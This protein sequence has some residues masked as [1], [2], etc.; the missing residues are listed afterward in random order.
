MQHMRIDVI[1][2]HFVF[3][4]GFA[5]ILLGRALNKPVVV[6]ARGSDITLGLKLPLVNRLIGWTLQHAA[7]VIAVSA[8]LKELM[9]AHG[10][11]PDKV[12][13]IP[14][15]VDTQLFY[16][17]DQDAARHALGLP[18][19]AKIVL[20]VCSLVEL[21]GVD[22]L[23]EAAAL[24]RARYPGACRILVVGKGPE[25]ER[26]Q[27][28]IEQAGLG[29]MVRLVG[30]VPNRELVNWYNAA[31]LFFLGSSREG[32][33]NVV[34][35]ALA[36]GTPVVAT[37]VSGIPEIVDHD[38]LGLLVERTPAAFAAGILAAFDTCWDRQFILERGRRRSWEQVAREVHAVFAKVVDG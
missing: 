17:L 14:N 24:V 37:N 22:L 11:D 27:R 6:S 29:D 28:Q 38:G 7:R 18:A 16:P 35:E 26:L 2:A 33:P 19:D 31:D 20:T 12:T 13:V 15:G 21:K 5:A 30:T 1:D 10:T 36:C 3:P 4:D 8:S 25:R 23:I 34:C 32:W 9:V